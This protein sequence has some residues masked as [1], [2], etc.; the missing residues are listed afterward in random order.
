MTT[1]GINVVMDR[2]AVGGTIAPA[3]E[4]DIDGAN[5]VV[6]SEAV[7]TTTLAGFTIVGA[8]VVVVRASVSGL[9]PS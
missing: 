3:E 4:T 8:N 2:L 1:V 9:M 6:V 7:G 5:V